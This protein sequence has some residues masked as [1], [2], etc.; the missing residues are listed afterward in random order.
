MNR[1]QVFEH[2]VD[3]HY[4]SVSMYAHFLLGEVQTVEDVVHQAFMLAF[5]RLAAD[6][7]FEG[8]PGKWLRGC[9]RNLVRDV[10]RQKRRLPQD[11]ADLLH[12]V[13]AA[14]DDPGE[15]IDRSSLRAALRECLQG[16]QSADR[17]L[18]GR[19]Y[20][21]GLRVAEIARRLDLNPATTRVRLFRIRQAL[22]ACVES[23]FA[24][25]VPR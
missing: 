25:E 4:E 2:M 9:V 5:E 6:R 24:G 21:H 20:E 18:I 16:L 13:L 10:W 14:A 23:R 3:D 17:D 1:K 11:V 15:A 12:G 22:K 7:P 8:D 19:R